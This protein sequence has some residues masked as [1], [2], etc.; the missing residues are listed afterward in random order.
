MALLRGQKCFAQK[1]LKISSYDH[2]TCKTSST[3]AAGTSFRRLYPAAVHRSAMSASLFVSPTLSFRF[4]PIFQQGMP[5]KSVY[6]L[7][8]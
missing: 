4:K 5:R 6:N 2:L 1:P 8:Y 7:L 3:A